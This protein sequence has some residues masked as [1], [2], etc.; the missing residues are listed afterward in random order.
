MTKA[1]P[2]SII[3]A[4]VVAILLPS[5]VGKKKHREALNSLKRDYEQQIAIL[6]T[7]LYLLSDAND[8]L[9]LD[10]AEKRGANGAL[11]AMQDKLLGQ[12]DQ[13]QAEIERLKEAAANKEETL[14]GTIQQ[15]N[16]EIAAKQKQLDDILALMDKRAAQL[17]E[18]FGL[19]QDSL[20][21]FDSLTYSVTRK[22]DAISIELTE[23][24]MFVRGSTGRIEDEGIA[25]LEK[26]SA[27]MINYPALSI[28]VIGHTDNRP[29]PRN[30]ITSNWDYGALRASTVV[31]ALIKEFVLRPNQ[32]MVASKGEFAPRTSNE[33]TEGQAQNRRIELLI[34]APQSD[35]TRDIRR[36]VK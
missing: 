9:E 3:S 13:L 12:I 25:A 19:L 16:K 33:T 1:I 4:L 15:K 30:S 29:V 5:C 32:V 21:S 23:E 20:R 10:L 8:S 22:K 11:V 36:I 35:L 14:D 26:I 34:E 31:K 24:M 7:N 28:T 18:V 6:D 17:A 2:L 27:I